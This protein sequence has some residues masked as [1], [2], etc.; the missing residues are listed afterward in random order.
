MA[1]IRMGVVITFDE[2]DTCRFDLLRAAV[3]SS[4]IGR[5]APHITL[6]PPMEVSLAQLDEARSRLIALAAS[7]APFEV[8]VAGVGR[9][10]NRRTVSYLGVDDDGSLVA[11]YRRLGGGPE[12][13][14][15]PHVTLVEDVSVKQACAIESA[16]AAVEVAVKVDRIT[17]LV[18]HAIGG[19]HRWSSGAEVFLGY[20]GRRVRGPFDLQLSYTTIPRSLR[21]DRQPERAVIAYRSGVPVAEAV[22]RVLAP[23][24]VELERV[25][26]SDPDDR[27]Y[28]LGRLVLRELLDYLS[29]VTFATSW[30]HPMLEG[31]P[32]FATPPGFARSVGLD[33]SRRW[34]LRSLST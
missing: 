34:K 17:L 19:G 1:S 28:G 10:E 18:A 13:P 4:G 30:D 8:R 3:G 24:L 29:P 7:S 11:L 27:G 6:I 14:F 21:L 9:F 31:L 25:V 20:G 22:V 15:I 23:G 12:R 33:Y 26:V 32:S 16:L 2:V 5:I